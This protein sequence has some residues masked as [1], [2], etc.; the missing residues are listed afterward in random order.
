MEQQIPPKKSNIRDI[1]ILF[2][3]P[4]VIA[5]FAVIATFLPRA[6]ANPKYDFIY[7][8]CKYDCQPTYRVD[9]DG[10]IRSDTNL[11][12][13]ELGSSALRDPE[14]LSNTS[15]Y[16]FSTREDSSKLISIET[17]RQYKLD[18][19]S[20]SPDG[21]SLTRNNSSGGFFTSEAYNNGW[22]LK[23]G[24]LSKPLESLEKS[25]YSNNIILV[26]WVIK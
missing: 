15:M 12:K 22:Y 23:N 13:L 26:G 10:R 4:I 16:Y 5:L 21:Y 17:A 25:Y 24:M 19:S 8:S 1:A 20:K 11:K 14:Y 9:D 3:I 2:A 18:P 7:V 6:M